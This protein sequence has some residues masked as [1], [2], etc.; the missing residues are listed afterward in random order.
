MIAFQP[1]DLIRILPEIVL[2][3]FAILIMV[4]EPFVAAQHK[5]R[6]GWVALG[7]MRSRTPRTVRSIRLK[8]GRG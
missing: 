8:K 7:S 2:S 4:A 3:G 6:L 5:S 1:T